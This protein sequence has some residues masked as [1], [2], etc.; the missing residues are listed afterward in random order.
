M[1][2]ADW[3]NN[4]IKV[5]V[6]FHSIIRCYL[7]KPIYAFFLGRYWWLKSLCILTRACESKTIAIKIPITKEN[8]QTPS[9]TS[10]YTIPATHLCTENWIQNPQYNPVPTPLDRKGAS[11]VTQ[12]DGGRGGMGPHLSSYNNWFSKG[13]ERFAR[14]VT[15]VKDKTDQYIRTDTP[16]G[17]E[18]EQ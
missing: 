4:N 2:W 18:R 8:S 9:C 10:W 1:R 15:R 14:C 11:E 12:V 7:R 16:Q 17:G 5:V 13:T 6:W 3:I